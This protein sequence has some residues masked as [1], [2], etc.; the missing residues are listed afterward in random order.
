MSQAPHLA[1]ETNRQ[2]SASTPPN[3][4]DAR[5]RGIP[6]LGAGAIYWTPESEIVVAWFLIPKHWPRC[7]G[8]DVGWKY[9][10]A[11]WVAIDPATGVCYAYHEYYRSEAEA[12]IHAAAI[13]AMGDWIPAWWIRPAAGVRQST[14][15][16]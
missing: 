3:M 9:T 2:M 11:V 4:R 6:Q 14:G 15:E 13:R 8:L 7:Y 5:L 1:E 10:A 16:G 12:E